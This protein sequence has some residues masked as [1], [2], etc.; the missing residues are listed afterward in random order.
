MQ[1]GMST[2][3]AL[4]EST[5]LSIRVLGDVERAAR[6]VSDRT[7]HRLEQGLLWKS[8]SARAILTGGEPVS[9]L[10]PS[11]GEQAVPADEQSLPALW[12][13]AL[14]DAYAIAGE[15]ARPGSM[16]QGSRLAQ[17]LNEIGKALIVYSTAGVSPSEPAATRVAQ[18]KGMNPTVLRIALG[19]YMRKL[20]EERLL[21]PEDVAGRLG[22]TSSDIKSF[23]LGR[24]AFG[25][26]RLQ[27]LLMLYGVDDPAIRRQCLSLAR[28]AGFSGWWTGY[29]DVLPDW[30]RDYLHFERNADAI[31]TY[32]AQFIP[33]L[34]QTEDYARAVIGTVPGDVGSLERKV[35]LRKGRQYI[36]TDPLGPR[37][38][39]VIDEFAL[40]RGPADPKIMRD[41]IAYL[42]EKS[43]LS[44]VTIQVLPRS[45]SRIIPPGPFSLLRFSD[46]DKPDI[47]YLE[48]H[49]SALYIDSEKDVDVYSELMEMICFTA[50]TPDESVVRLE[51]WLDMLPR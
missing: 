50:L 51:H 33:G 29:E 14:S 41:Q 19:R 47:V 38:W 15:L 26:G 48:Q 6:K 34:L 10:E 39:A 40:D 1:L 35:R 30:F 18:P 31:R 28:K 20:R 43:R 8:G 25:E 13:H 24:T 3:E 49:T 42:I 9:T 36:L 16:D 45:Q 21:T 17:A 7:L 2:R 23:E 5:G 12:M 46:K 32:E 44:S 37:L 4:A 22:C 11:Y 27:G